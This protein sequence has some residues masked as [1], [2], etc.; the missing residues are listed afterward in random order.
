MINKLEF[1]GIL[2]KF[3][4]W[5]T[6][7]IT[8]GYLDKF[9]EKNKSNKLTLDLG[10]ADSPYSKFFKNRIGF[11]IVDGH[12]VDLVGDAHSLPFEDNKFEIILCTEVLEHLHSPQVALSEM[13]RVLNKGGILILTTRFIFPIHSAPYD[14]YR[15]TEYGLRY[16]LKDKWEIVELK[17]ETNTAK[18]IAILLQRIGYQ[19]EIRGGIILK[20]FIFLSAKLIIFF[21]K[22]VCSKE[23]NII[24]SGYYVVCRKI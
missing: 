9:I 23:R 3:K 15:Y 12:G 20:M 14:Y 6:V 10:C 18:T 8:R 4:M 16:L 21:S 7:K 2:N 19:K 24:T 13:Y 17:E 5:L 11:D 22:D 1:M